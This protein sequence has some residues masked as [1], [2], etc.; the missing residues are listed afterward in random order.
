MAGLANTRI[1]TL[2]AKEHMDELYHEICLF[3]ANEP[4]SITVKDD[5]EKGLHIT[6]FEVK[7]T[8]NN[9]PLLIGE[10]AYNLR[11]GL[12][13]LAWQLALLS[14]RI[15][16]NKTAFPIHRTGRKEA[17]RDLDAPRK[18]S[19]EKRSRPLRRFNPIIEEMGSLSTPSGSST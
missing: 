1:K 3:L 18:T 6:R 13:Q 9:I 4:I 5:L 8:P 12:D 19:H 17:N 14:G 15:P 2:R 16:R 10:I 11:S 7:I